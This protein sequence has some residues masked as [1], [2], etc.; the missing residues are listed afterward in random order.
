MGDVSEA[1][2]YTNDQATKA[3]LQEAITGWLP[4]VS[5]P[6]DTVF[7]FFSGHG[8]QLADDNG[9]ESDKQ[10]ELLIPYDFMS[11]TVFMS[12][13]NKAK[14]G[15]LPPHLVQR[16]SAA[17]GLFQRMRLDRGGRSGIDA[18]RAVSV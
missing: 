14:E 17:L 5:R 18:R 11:A 16:V 7:I 6:G 15:K 8:G 9:D 13:V 4:K 12:L 3:N 2:I 10:D 1:K